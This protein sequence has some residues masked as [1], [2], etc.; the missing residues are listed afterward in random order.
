[1]A[2]IDREGVSLYYEYHPSRKPNAPTLLLSHGYSATSAMW[3]G[4][5]AALNPDYSVITWDM[6]GHGESDSPEDVSLYSEKLSVEDMAALLDV[7]GV[8]QAFIGGLSLGGYMT[9]AFHRVYPER[10]LALLLFDTGPGYKSEKARAGWN[11][12]ASER[13]ANLAKIGFEALN[14]SAEVRASTHRSVTGLINAAK[15]ML[16][17]FDDRII[18]SLPDIALPTLVLVGA[19]DQPFLVPTDYMAGKIPGSR[20]VVIPKAGHA[21]NI[22]QPDLFNK[23]VLE[24]LGEVQ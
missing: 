24:F 20:K 11:E 7:C 23:A 16:S 22:D 8:Q 3:K 1:M 10:C 15:G 17:Q 4:Q 9:L 19:E 6:R 21:S 12:M 14:T 2:R 18:Q 13:A 5:L